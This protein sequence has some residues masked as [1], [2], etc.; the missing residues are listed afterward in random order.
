MKTVRVLI[1]GSSRE[2]YTLRS[3]LLE[4]GFVCSIAYSDEDVFRHIAEQSPDIVLL[5]MDSRV[6]R[7]RELI[8]PI[9]H[10]KSL[11][12]IALLKPDSLRLED[13]ESEIDDFVIEPYRE[14][15]IAVRIRR[16][17]KKTA[18]PEEENTEAKIYIA[19]LVIDQ[20]KCEVTVAGKVV[21]LAFKEYELL[22]FLVN[23]RGRVFT[24]QA[25]LDKV[26]GYDY[27][28]G[29]RTVDVHVRRLRSKIEDSSHSFIDTIRSI[30]YRFKE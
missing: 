26:W 2:A 9:R 1:I 22:K 16:L 6:P 28:G 29:D 27:F 20:A 23:N 7:R 15:E 11:P 4:K 10:E 13:A 18:A 5:E 17:L 30:G 24:R 14:L 8:E 3:Q 19:D 12:V 25:L 21:I